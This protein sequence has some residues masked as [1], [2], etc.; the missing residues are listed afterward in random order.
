MRLRPIDEPTRDG[1]V[2]LQ[3]VLQPNVTLPNPVVVGSA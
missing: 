2:A 3:V 1:P